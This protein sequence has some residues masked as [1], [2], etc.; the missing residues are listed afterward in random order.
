MKK[1]KRKGKPRGKSW[2]GQIKCDHCGGSGYHGEMI[3]PECKGSGFVKRKAKKSYSLDQ[4]P[5][6]LADYGGEMFKVDN[7]M[8]D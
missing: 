1:S 3:C 5:D 4:K 7:W 2:S 6:R 8:P